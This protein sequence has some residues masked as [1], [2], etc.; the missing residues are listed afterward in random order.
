MGRIAVAFQSFV[1]ALTS[2]EKALQ[3]EAV[4]RAGALP[5]EI[6]DKQPAPAISP[7]KQPLPPARSEAITLL[8][9]LQREARLV[10]L[11]KQPLTHFSDEQIGAA[12]RNVLGESAAVLD[13]FF[14]LQPVTAAEE[15]SPCDVPQGYDPA[16]FKL[17]G[18]V[19]GVGPFRGTL[20]HHG[21][22]ATAV[23]LPEWVGS[24]D[25]ALVIA[26]AEV[27]I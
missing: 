4:L 21:W 24:K 5:R 25:S 17:I 27:E 9:A 22:R 1:A 23:K 13:R 11:I 3:I 26:P 15:N 12:A 7:T 2:H 8:A 10:D 16:R 14:Q 18:R 6:S 20:I 19:E